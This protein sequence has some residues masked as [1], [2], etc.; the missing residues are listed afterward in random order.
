MLKKVFFAAIVFFF[1]AP[2]MV[3]GCPAGSSAAQVQ[4]TND[5]SPPSQI[6][7]AMIQY[8]PGLDASNPMNTIASNAGFQSSSPPTAYLVDVKNGALSDNSSG[9]VNEDDIIVVNDNLILASAIS[10]PITFT[11]T[12]NTPNAKIA[13]PPSM[14]SQQEMN[15]ENMTANSHPLSINSQ[16]NSANFDGTVADASTGCFQNGQSA[17]NC[18][19]TMATTSSPPG[20]SAQSVTN[21][22]VAKKLLLIKSRP[23]TSEVANTMKCPDFADPVMGYV[24]SDTQDAVQVTLNPKWNDVSTRKLSPFASTDVVTSVTVT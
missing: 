22:V 7:G 14:I 10:P 11:M 2:V 24:T 8:D 16:M 18:K 5:V 19:M 13:R 23:I 17:A 15:A 21:V 9:V 12:M 1:M 6:T 20:P 4:L 3:M